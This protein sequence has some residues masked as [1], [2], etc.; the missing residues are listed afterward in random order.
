MHIHSPRGVVRAVDDVSLTVNAR[1]AVAIVGESG[2]G[3]SMTAL[4]LMRLTPPLGRIVGGRVTFQGAD[5]LALDDKQ[6]RSLRGS[7]IAAV[8]QDPLTFLNPVM[9]IADQVEEAILL[10]QDVRPR[11]ARERAL[12]ALRLVRIPDPERIARSFP[13]QLSGGMRQRVLIAIAIACK[14]VLLIADEPTTALDVTIQAQIMELLAR[15]RQELGSSLL[16]ITHDLGVVAESCDRVY[17]M[18]AGQIVEHGDVFSIFEAPQHPYTQGLLAVNLSVDRA[19]SRFA[20]IDGQVP[21]LV[22]PP[23]GCRFHPRCPHVMDIC[24]SDAPPVVELG[25]GQWARCWLHVDGV[26]EQQLEQRPR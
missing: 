2:S 23:T 14:P 11:E 25:G 26:P 16:L 20:T 9:R 22:T 6:M 4:T 10:H 1:E 24:R 15:L 5:L 19:V 3:K 21:N 17:V 13:H 7:R 18:Y 12:E 8:F